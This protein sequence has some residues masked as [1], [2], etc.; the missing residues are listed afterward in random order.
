MGRK[1]QKGWYRYY[2]IKD[3]TLIDEHFEEF[4]S[5]L[6]ARGKNPFVERKYSFEKGRLKYPKKEGYV[7]LVEYIK[8]PPKDFILQKIQ[9][10]HDKIKNQE[11]VLKLIKS[12]ANKAIE[13]YLKIMGRDA[14]IKHKIEKIK[15]N[16]N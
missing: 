9:E 7:Y 2:V 11:Y 15:N 1:S 13:K 14:I 3:N 16:I 5:S 6:D 8:K 4:K 10:E 12:D